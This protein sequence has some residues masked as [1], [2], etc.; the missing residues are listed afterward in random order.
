MR[1]TFVRHAES[2]SNLD[3]RWQGQSNSPLSR[4]GQKQARALALRFAGRPFDVVIASDLDRTRETARAFERPLE[5]DPDWREIDVGAWEGLTHGEVQRRY[6]EEVA[7]LAS[8]R[9]DVRI[10]GGESWEDVRARVRA[11]FAKLRARLGERD[12]ALVVTHGGMLSTLAADLLGVFG[13]HPRPL[14]RLSNT[15]LFEVEILGDAVRVLAYN[16]A[17]HLA[18]YGNV[19][20]ERLDNKSAV[21]ALLSSP[22]SGAAHAGASHEGA[23]ETAAFRAFHPEARVFRDAAT[24]ASDAALREAVE[25]HRGEIFAVAE[26][27]E[28]VAN[29]TAQLVGFPSDAPAHLAAPD[30]GAYAHI[31]VSS[32]RNSLAEYNLRAHLQ[33]PAGR[34]AR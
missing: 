23:P 12:H 34:S 33:A 7:E 14:G 6:P 28:A 20:A 26:S 17:S 2:Q 15:A 10:G 19:V 9:F 25:A 22:N 30:A 8:G 11:A 5:L 32:A 27:P 24:L 1:I 4:G 16:D 13:V 3:G 21:L 29:R 31:I 18:P